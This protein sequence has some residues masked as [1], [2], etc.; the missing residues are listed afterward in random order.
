MF[1]DKT[2]IRPMASFGTIQAS[3][4]QDLVPA[5]KRELKT[6]II[7]HELDFER[8]PFSGVIPGS[9]KFRLTP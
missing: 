3:K 5:L 6:P 1:A 2:K 4:I 9:G 7:S 8:N